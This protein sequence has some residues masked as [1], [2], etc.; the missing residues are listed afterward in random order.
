MHSALTRLLAK[1][2][3]RRERSAMTYVAFLAKAN[4]SPKRTPI[5]TSQTWCLVPASR[6]PVSH[7]A[8]ASRQRWQLAPSVLTVRRTPG[9]LR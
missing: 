8:S 4:R 3:S 1:N 5:W 6:P 2:S 9:Q 7:E